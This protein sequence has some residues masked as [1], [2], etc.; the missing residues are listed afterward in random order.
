MGYLNTKK[1]NERYAEKTCQRDQ[2]ESNNNDSFEGA[3]DVTERQKQDIEVLKATIVNESNLP[4]IQTKLKSTLAYRQKL[5]EN[6]ELDLKEF[7]PY[8]F[9]DPELV[10]RMDILI[11][12]A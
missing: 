11:F 3:I 6:R 1:K 4:E 8:F 5:L 9:T 12:T 10:Y 7:F 2:N